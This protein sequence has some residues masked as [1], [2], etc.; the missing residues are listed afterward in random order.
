MNFE[1][2]S[3]I[4]QKNVIGILVGIILNLWITWGIINILT[5][6]SL[7]THKHGMSSH[8]IS[9]AVLLSYHFC[10]HWSST[11][12]FLEELFLCIHNLANCLAQEA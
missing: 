11:F 1:M 8:F 10:V 9:K 4:L 3:C 2:V 5:I 6:L 12:N 7:Q